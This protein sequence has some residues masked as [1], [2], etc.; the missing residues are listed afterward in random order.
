MKKFDPA[1]LKFHPEVTEDEKR[2]R[3]EGVRLTRMQKYAAEIENQNDEFER[4]ELSLP[5]HVCR[6]CHHY[7]ADRHTCPL[8]NSDFRSLKV[9]SGDLISDFL[10]GYVTS[11]GKKSTES[12]YLYSENHNENMKQSLKTIL[13]SFRVSEMKK[14]IANCK[15]KFGWATPKRISWEQKNEK[16]LVFLDELFMRGKRDAK[17]KVNADQAAA[18]MRSA[19]DQ[20]TKHPL[21]KRTEWLTPSQIKSW[22][23]SRAK[24]MPAKLK[25]YYEEQ[26]T[27]KK[28]GRKKKKIKKETKRRKNSEK[29]LA[30]LQA[31]KRKREEEEEFEEAEAFATTFAHLGV[32]F[33]AA[34]SERK[35]K[36]RRKKKKETKENMQKAQELSAQRRRARRRVASRS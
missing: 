6:Q 32:A 7:Y 35:K 13:Q 21:F 20:D 15:P 1:E 23:G 25:K 26:K 5:F 30:R 16:Q 22:F 33:A 9:K 36:K 3:T 14:L 17:K 18:F 31:Q 11:T 29:R 2:E 4:R 10:S 34:E 8:A 28:K 24:K 19:I 12:T 27:A